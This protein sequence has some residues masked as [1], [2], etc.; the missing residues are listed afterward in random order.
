MAGDRPIN[1]LIDNLRENYKL[2]VYGA[3]G[4]GRLRESIRRWVEAEVARRLAEARAEAPGPPAEIAE[5]LRAAPDPAAMNEPDELTIGTTIDFVDLGRSTIKARDCGRVLLESPV[6]DGWVDEQWLSRHSDAE[7]RRRGPDMTDHTPAVVI[8]EPCGEPLCP[9]YA[10]RPAAPPL[11]APDLAR[12]RRDARALG[13]VGSGLVNALCDQLER[14]RAERDASVA[15]AERAE[16]EVV[17]DE[18]ARVE[19]A[20]AEADAA[21]ERARAT[22]LLCRLQQLR[23]EAAREDRP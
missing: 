18:L 2:P 10:F 23:A 20:Y 4:R 13:V 9:C 11:P 8:D 14:A 15:R 16:A 17:R 21:G 19:L 3:D 5:R 7:R 12:V 6:F 1:E 22:A